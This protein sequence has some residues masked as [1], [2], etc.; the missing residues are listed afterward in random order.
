MAEKSFPDWYL[1]NVALIK[2][3]Y[4][5]ISKAAPPEREMGRESW[6]I[7]LAESLSDSVADVLRLQ[8]ECENYW[9]AYLAEKSAELKEVGKMKTVL[10][11]CKNFDCPERR[12]YKQLEAM[13]KTIEQRA[14]LTQSE[15]K[16]YKMQ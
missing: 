15:L 7:I 16:F 13:A 4:A 8:G 9:L 5:K 10:D 12:A 11:L 2:Q 14:S 6:L 3:I 1:E